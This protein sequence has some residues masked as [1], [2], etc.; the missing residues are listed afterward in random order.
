MFFQIAGNMSNEIALV[1]IEFFASVFV[2]MTVKN[3][4]G[5]GFKLT[6]R[7][8]EFRFFVICLRMVQDITGNFKNQNLDQA[9][10][11]TEGIFE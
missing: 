3:K 8:F 4:L 2:H 1:A 10:D 5:I 11:L 7:T 9:N 6:E